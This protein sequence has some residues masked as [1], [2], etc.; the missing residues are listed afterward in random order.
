MQDFENFKTWFESLDIP[1]TAAPFVFLLAISLSL[2]LL[3]NWLK[4]ERVADRA[5]DGITTKTRRSARIRAATIF[6][7]VTIFA[8]VATTFTQSILFLDS[9]SYYT[10]AC[11]FLFSAVM[12]GIISSIQMMLSIQHQLDDN[13]KDLKDVKKDLVATQKDLLATQKEIAKSRTDPKSLQNLH[14]ETRSFREQMHHQA[15]QLQRLALRDDQLRG[16]IESTQETMGTIDRLRVAAA[17]TESAPVL[18]IA[19]FFVQEFFDGRFLLEDKNQAQIMGRQASIDAYLALWQFLLKKQQELAGQR[20]L[21]VRALHTVPLSLWSINPNTSPGR[22]SVELL[23]IQRRFIHTGG[24]FFRIAIDRERPETRRATIDAMRD[25]GIDIAYI[26]FKNKGQDYTLQNPPK[27]GFVWI[28]DFEYG[29][30]WVLY[31]KDRRRKPIVIRTN[32]RWNKAA[33]HYDKQW[34]F[35]ANCVRELQQRGDRRLWIPDGVNI[36]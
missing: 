10:I 19:N 18:H 33:R 17:R 11:N 25:A 7:G 27:G 34:S 1:W 3:S 32:M 6:T 13:S 22:R 36:T 26:F 29:Q 5:P 2:W 20:R 28:P 23:D 24:R 9:V 14:D 31:S 4:K 21:T 12:S 30:G 15:Q 35:W 16:V 8:G